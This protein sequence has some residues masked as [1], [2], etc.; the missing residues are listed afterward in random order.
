LHG[1]DWS[2]GIPCCEKPDSSED[3]EELAPEHK[4]LASD[5]L[6]EEGLP[7]V[8]SEPEPLFAGVCRMY[9]YRRAGNQDVRKSLV[10][11][12]TSRCAS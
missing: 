11:R 4:G 12:G 7:N 6:D 1:V 3:A 10:G 8:I 9:C 2:K 5:K